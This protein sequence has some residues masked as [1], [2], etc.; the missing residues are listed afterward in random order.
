M[1]QAY[2]NMLL[3]EWNEN[4]MMEIYTSCFQHELLLFNAKA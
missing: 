1:K 4:N 2:E 3:K